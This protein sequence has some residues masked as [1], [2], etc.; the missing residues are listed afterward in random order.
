MRTVFWVSVGIAVIASLCCSSGP[1]PAVQGEAAPEFTFKNQS[2]KELSL[3]SFA[4]K[5]CL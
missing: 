2:G 5:S 1:G 3:S 4:A